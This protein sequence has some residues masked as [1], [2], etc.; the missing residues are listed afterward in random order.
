MPIFSRT[1]SSSSAKSCPGLIDF[2]FACDD[3][4]AY[5][6]A[7][8][9]NAWCFEKDFSFNLTKGTALLAGYQSVRPLERRRESG[10][11]DAGARLGAALHA[12]PAL[13][14]ADGPRWRRWS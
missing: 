13:R 10:A 8:C 7:T 11:A 3:L 5:D 14:L 2:Y 4:Y 1:M 9:L 6:V 12:D